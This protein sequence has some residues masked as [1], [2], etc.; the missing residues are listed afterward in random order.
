MYIRAWERERD[1]VVVVVVDGVLWQRL[2]SHGAVVALLSPHI[3]VGWREYKEGKRKKIWRKKQTCWWFRWLTAPYIVWS[4]RRQRSKA[5][6]HI[7]L[8]NWKKKEET[9][10]LAVFS[11]LTFLNSNFKYL[12]PYGFVL[13]VFI[14]FGDG[15]T[16]WRLIW[17]MSTFSS[18]YV[19]N[20]I[21]HYVSIWKWG[22]EHF[23]CL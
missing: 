19:A 1:Y 6:T 3:Q 7:S 17:K 16:D 12:A 15:P 14:F 23:I 10:G 22:M 8:E 18:A 5:H 4:I 2:K 11:F 13:C 20:A 9:I 21:Q